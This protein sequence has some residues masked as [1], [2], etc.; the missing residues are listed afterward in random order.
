MKIALFISICKQTWPLQAILVSYWLS[1][2]NIFS[3]ETALPNEPKHGRKHI[4]KVLYEECSFRP[5]SL[6]N[7]AATWNSRFW[8]VDFEKSSPLQPKLLGSIYERSSITIAHFVLIRK[9]A[10]PPQTIIVADWSIAKTSS[11][12][13]PL[14]QMNW[15][16]VGRIYDMSS[17]AIA[18]FVYFM[19]LKAAFNTISVISWW[20]VLLVKKQQNSEKTTDL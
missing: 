11:P 13:K 1:C 18:H 3:S 14:G 20:S 17:I 4:R 10:W 7:M 8:L 12:L 19:V 9:Q 2:T 5:D 6:T 16:L 15:N